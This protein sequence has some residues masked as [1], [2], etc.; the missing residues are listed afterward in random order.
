MDRNFFIR[1]KYIRGCYCSRCGTRQL[2]DLYNYRKHGS[3]CGFSPNDVYEPVEEEEVCGYRLC[4]EPGML[5]IEVCRPEL[6]LRPGFQD[7]YRGGQWTAVFRAE[8]PV[9]ERQ[10]RILR[11]ET[12]MN[13]DIW[14]KEIRDG[15]LSRIQEEEDVSVIRRVFPAIADIFSLQMF[16]YIYQT[17]GYPW[18]PVLTPRQAERLA[19][20]P[21]SPAA[22][23]LT[24]GEDGRED[25][26]PVRA[27]LFRE[28]SSGEVILKAVFPKNPKY[29]TFLISRDY[30]YTSVQPDLS[31]LFTRDLRP[32][33]DSRK[34][35]LKFAEFYPS[36]H[37]KEFLG[38]GGKDHTHQFL[39]PLLAANY[40]KLSELAAG[41]AVWQ[42][43]G[44]LSRPEFQVDPSFYRNLKDAFGLPV[45]CLRKLPGQMFAQMDTI[46][47]LAEVRKINPAFLN[48][49]HLNQAML[50]F[51]RDCGLAHGRRYARIRI[52]RD[53]SDAQIL[54]ILR[55]LYDHPY[56]Y[57]YYCDYLNLC[58]ETDDFEDGLT[59]RD[60]REAHD[61]L[62]MLDTMKRNNIV[63]GKF[64][65]Q[66]RSEPYRQLATDYSE[67][68][69]EVFGEDPYIIVLPIRSMDLEHEGRE[70]HNCV[71]TYI[72]AVANGQAR[73]VFLRRREQPEAAFG[74]I[75]VRPGIGL[76]QAKAFANRHL[77][78]K[79]QKFVRKWAGAKGIKINTYDLDETA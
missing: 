51:M 67:E 45:S 66:I 12:G 42:L 50:Q 38:R 68:D 5:A 74:T 34:A 11:N 76:I 1:G 37:L 25:V 72:N 15:R 6:L 32:D 48:F 36:Y 53:L 19:G 14:L 52:A 63:E 26:I 54:K 21:L 64:Q 70:M 31:D 62:L 33:A 78:R 7:R 46:P 57:E 43:A 56:F 55:Y 27:A 39:I 40:H 35:I 30:L 59:P 77:D 2:Q 29:G 58:A 61:R 41:A 47:M 44:Q 9:G 24:Q 4:A 17:K 71:R 8:F 60:V 10:I 3:V 18:N 23:E 73:I 75:E 49:E 65:E 69:K 79:A 13:L 20:K 16:V 28:R 22:S